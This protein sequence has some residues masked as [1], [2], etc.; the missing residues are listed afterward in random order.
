V[1]GPNLI[2]LF[3]ITATANIKNNISMAIDWENSGTTTY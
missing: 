3:N 1:L 2:A